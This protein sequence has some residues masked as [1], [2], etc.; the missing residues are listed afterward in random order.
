MPSAIRPINKERMPGIL[1]GDQAE[2]G[3]HGSER[4]ETGDPERRRRLEPPRM[5][6]SPTTTQGRNALAVNTAPAAQ[7]HDYARMPDRNMARQL[8]ARSVTH[9]F[10]R[11]VEC[12][13]R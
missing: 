10:P 1:A 9:G 8:I 4:A 11:G 3:K 5:E 6:V 12:Q 13:E 2:R 7:R